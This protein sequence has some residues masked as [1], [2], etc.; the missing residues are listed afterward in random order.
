M[1]GDEADAA[2]QEEEVPAPEG[3]LCE[4]VLAC[5]VAAGVG[6]KAGI[7][8]GAITDGGGTEGGIEAM[9]GAMAWVWA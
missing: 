9:G 5:V 3:V 8:V 2:G 6:G 1:S 7:M 4:V